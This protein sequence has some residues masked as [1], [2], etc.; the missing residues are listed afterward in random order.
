MPLDINEFRIPSALFLVEMISR[1]HTYTYVLHYIFIESSVWLYWLGQGTGLLMWKGVVR[2]IF[3]SY[4]VASVPRDTEKMSP[5]LNS[6]GQFA[7]SI[8]RE[9][10]WDVQQDRAGAIGQ[11]TR[12]VCTYIKLWVSPHVDILH[13]PRNIWT[14]LRKFKLLNET[15]WISEHTGMLHVVWMGGMQCLR[16]IMAYA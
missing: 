16:Y 1:T 5:W 4:R 6:T 8:V 11:K 14:S 13:P 9:W 2:L 12:N 15:Y 10:W 7:A 3:K